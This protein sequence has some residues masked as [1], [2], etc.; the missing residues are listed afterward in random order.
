MQEPFFLESQKQKRHK[1]LKIELALIC[2]I[3]TA[4]LVSFLCITVGKSRQGRC[5]QNICGNRWGLME[6]DSWHSTLTQRREL[7]G[8]VDKGKNLRL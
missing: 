8:S 6:E 2:R 1:S 7:S 4:A 5:Y 3:S